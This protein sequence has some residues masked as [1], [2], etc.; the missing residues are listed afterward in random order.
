ML[1][2]GM[3][4]TWEAWAFGKLENSRAYATDAV[5]QRM[6][7]YGF[8][9]Q[10]ATPLV[11]LLKSWD[12]RTIGQLYT[13][14]W[15]PR[16]AAVHEGRLLAQ[17]L[18]C[19]G[20]HI[21]ENEGGDI[22]PLLENSL[23][24]EGISSGSALA[25]Y[26]PDITREGEKVQSSWLFNFLK[27]PK[28]GEIRPW[29]RTRMPTFD[30]TDEEANTLVAYF[31]SYSKKTVSFSHMPTYELTSQQRSAAQ[32]LVSR[33]YFSCFSCHQQGVKKPEGPPEGWAP[34]L[35]MAK[36]RL[37]PD[38]ITRWIRDPQGFQPGTNM[39]SFYPD[40]VPGDVL[41]GN[42]DLQLLSLRNY[43]MNL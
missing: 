3:E 25:Y 30:L 27:T 19:M 39:P 24:K 14:P 12:G 15:G 10:E 33:D 6:P 43:L 41:E 13:I 2:K 32:T 29:L 26:P 18:N 21:L 9:R 37:E 38:W 31:K 8:G 1:A 16:E 23:G 11:A 42:A 22:R 36:N 28:T 7:N 35:E 5:I 17:K 40:A 20:C 4:K 34:D